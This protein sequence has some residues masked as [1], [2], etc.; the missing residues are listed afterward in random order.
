MRQ[1]LMDF[2]RIKSLFEHL[3]QVQWI[4]LLYFNLCII[5]Y[6]YILFSGPRLAPSIA[7]VFRKD[8]APTKGV[9]SNP[10]EICRGK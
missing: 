1:A 3:K 6:H 10:P 5:Y 2:E 4:I 9:D 7:A 8:T